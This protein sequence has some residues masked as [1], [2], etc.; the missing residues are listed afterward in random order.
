MN[1]GIVK[2]MWQEIFLPILIN[3][4]VIFLASLVYQFIIIPHIFKGES[5]SFKVLIRAVFFMGILGFLF[6]FIIFWV[7][8]Q[9][10]LKRK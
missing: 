8:N 6:R 7:W 10:K 4:I 9:V 1:K 2:K 3:W 5:P